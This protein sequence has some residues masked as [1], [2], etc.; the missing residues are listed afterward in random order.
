MKDNNTQTNYNVIWNPVIALLKLII[1]VKNIYI[2]SD[3]NTWEPVENMETCKHL[4]EAF[5][6]QLARQKELKALRAQQQQHPV[7]VSSWIWKRIY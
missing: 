1:I 4:L 5:E 3:Q 7:Q 2:L 6:K